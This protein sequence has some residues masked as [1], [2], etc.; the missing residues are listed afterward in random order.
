MIQ[1]DIETASYAGERPSDRQVG[2]VVILNLV[3]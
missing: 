1:N 2:A 3:V